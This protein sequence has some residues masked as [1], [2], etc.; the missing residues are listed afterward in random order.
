MNSKISELMYNDKFVRR[1]V[2]VTILYTET[3]G[4]QR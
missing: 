2:H 4:T 3:L 1:L